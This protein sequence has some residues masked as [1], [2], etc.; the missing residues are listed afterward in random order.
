[1]AVDV[2]LSVGRAFSPDQERFIALLESTLRSQDLAPRTV[3]RN[4]FSANTPLR[5]I[6]EVLDRCDGT[7]VLAYARTLS[8]TFVDRPGSE[9][10]LREENVRLPT[11]WNQ[12]E[13][14]MS[15]SRGLPLLVVVENGLRDEGLLESRYDWYVQRVSLTSDALETAEFRGILADWAAQVKAHAEGRSSNLDKPAAPV[16]PADVTI[17]QLL[18]G[19]TIPQLWGA[20]GAM[21]TVL[22]AVATVAY[23]LGGS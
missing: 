14:A 16:A 8:M 4:D 9:V 15:Y 21:G 18:G 11:V 2:F 19:L 6:A 23:K 22:V 13:A 3:G 17:K 1:M 7:V 10:E 20:L 5:R 12:I